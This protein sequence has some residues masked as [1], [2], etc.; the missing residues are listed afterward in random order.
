MDKVNENPELL[1]DLTPSLVGK[2]RQADAQAGQMLDS[3]YRERLVGFCLG[4][5]NDRDVARDVVQDVFLKVLKSDTVPDNFR[6][7][8]YRICRNRCLDIHRASGRRRDDQTL[9]DHSL[10]NA[11]LTGRLTH[12]V[13][14][15]QWDY[16]KQLVEDLPDDQRESLLLRYVEGLS[17]AEIGEVLDLPE[18][19]VKSKLFHGLEKLRSHDSLVED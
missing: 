13:R 6:A 12:L 15:E 10:L 11:E 5:V 18:K 19:T 7:W 1:R 4:Y 17:R 3:M 9:P 14:K 2:L 8:I 16:L